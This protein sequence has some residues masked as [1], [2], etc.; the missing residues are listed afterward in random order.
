MQYMQH[1][2]YKKFIEPSSSDPDYQNREIV[3]NWLLAGLLGLIV[4]AFLNVLASLTLR[5]KSYILSRLFAIALLFIFSLSLYVF[6]R[7]QQKQSLAA[8]VLVAIFF[9]SA[10]F[11]L[12]RWGIADS[13]GITLFS[14]S[15]IMAG[16]LLG[17]RYSLYMLVLVSLTLTG[18]QYAKSQ[19]YVN[20]D[21]SW[22]RRPSSMTDVFSFTAIFAIIALVSWLFNRQMEQSLRRARRSE[23]ALKRQ[24]ALLEIKVKKR[25]RELEVA[26]LEKMQELYRFAELGRLSTAL[27]HD[28]ADHLS[29]VNVDIQGLDGNRKSSITHRIQENIGHIDTVVQRIRQQ[30]RGKSV[31]EVFD[32]ID[33]ISEIISILSFSAIEA[34]VSVTMQSSSVKKALSYKGDV[35]RFRQLILNL[36]SNAI[37]AYKGSPRQGPENRPVSV[38]VKRAS[39]ILIISVIDYGVGI[40]LE[41]Q[42][43]IFDQFYTTKEKGVGIGLFIVKQ[44]A[45]N[46]FKGTIS[47]VSDSG[48]GTTF[49]VR[50][51]K[52]YYAK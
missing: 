39:S 22:M 6:S 29:T 32:V 42:A 13:E 1:K 35:T 34:G 50:L 38:V 21:L 15:I 10:S 47:L 20:P 2:F 30:I 18:L 7:K 31:I 33:E 37:E 36:V 25:T 41:N 26:Q 23:K 4:V 51:P 5:H 8:V 45:E 9:L 27:F 44:I 52:S 28:L 46:D 24:K 17:A 14:L 49:T 19:R 11:V 40:G 12:Y 43:K 3:L 48:Q 16:I